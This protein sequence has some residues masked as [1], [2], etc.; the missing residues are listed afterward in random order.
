MKKRGTQHGSLSVRGRS[1]IVRYRRHMVGADGALLYAPTTETI[2]VAVGPKR[3]LKNDARIEADRVVAEANAVAAV[4]KQT[5]TLKQ[6]IDGRFRPERK[7]GLRLSA[8]GKN[9]HYEYVLRAHILPTFGDTQLRD[10]TAG[11]I[12]LLLSSK[13]V[14]GLSKQTVTHIRNVFSAVFRH[15]KMTGFWRGDLPTEGVKCHGKEAAQPRS[16]SV[17]QVQ[18][19]V[20]A[21]D[22]RYRPLVSPLAGTGLRVGECIA[23]RW[24]FCNLTDQYVSVDG[25]PIPAYSLAVVQTY[26]R[27]IWRQRRHCG[28]AGRSHFPR[29]HG[30]P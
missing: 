29:L 16:L 12:Q 26:S 14:G 24:K 4:P 7:Q 2:G 23:L 1:W 30:W 13:A 27:Q 19:L 8:K 25:V 21:M 6:F 22:A 11:R 15:A 28:R 20:A 10:I 9:T 3:M 5:A 17:E 18:L